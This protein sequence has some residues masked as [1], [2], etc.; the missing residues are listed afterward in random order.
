V[1]DELRKLAAAR[2][3]AEGPGQT[4]NAT[5]LVHEAY[6]RLI[7]Q[8]FVDWQNRA[9]FFGMAANMMR[10]ILVDHARKRAALKHGG[11][12]TRI[13]LEEVVSFPQPEP[14]DLVAVD[15][16]LDELALLDSIQG[17]IVEARFFGGLTIDETAEVLGISPSTVKREW[18][19]ARAWLF[20]KL[21]AQ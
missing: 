11:Q 6:L 13:A 15:D 10:R 18:A 8:R 1:Y 4:L 2:V 19:M 7:E 5:A 14:L 21:S 17:R 20:D 3:A 16:A 9:H 12:K